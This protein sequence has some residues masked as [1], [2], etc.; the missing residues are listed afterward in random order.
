MAPFELLYSG[1][2]KNRSDEQLELK[3][4]IVFDRKGEAITFEYRFVVFDKE[5]KIGEWQA[6][7]TF[8]VT[9]PSDVELISN[10]LYSRIAD[11]RHLIEIEI[12][13]RFPNESLR[14]GDTFLEFSSIVETVSHTLR[15]Q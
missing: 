9:D 15:S 1:Y 13:M 10:G 6:S 11:V 5:D 3:D 14:I 2:P 8:N 7:G 12:P 4:N